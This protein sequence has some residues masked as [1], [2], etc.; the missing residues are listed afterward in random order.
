M[1]MAGPPE[2]CARGTAPAAMNST[3]LMPKCSSR[4]VCSPTSAW[5]RSSCISPSGMLVRKHTSQSASLPS[6]P[7]SRSPSSVQSARSVSTRWASPASRQPPARTK[8]T[9][10]LPGSRYCG[11]SRRKRAKACSCRAW[12]FSGRNCA[13]E[14]TRRPPPSF[15]P[16]SSGRAAKA[17]VSQGGKT[18]VVRPGTRQSESMWPCVHEEFTMTT[19]ANR[20]TKPY[21]AANSW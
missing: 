14:S 5:P 12:F 16:R 17:A 1:S 9:R 18:V 15:C 11:A 21:N 2:L 3:T 7:F 10:S 8:R 13:R 6:P 19:S 4:M 20:P